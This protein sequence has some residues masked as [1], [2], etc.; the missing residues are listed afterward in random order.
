MEH[1]EKT[2]LIKIAHYYFVDGMTQ[3]EIA[4]KLHLSRQK[5]NRLIKE[6]REKGIV[7]IE[8]MTTENS[9]VEL[10]S[11]L[12]AQ[13][14]IGSGHYIVHVENESTIIQQLG[15]IGAEHFYQMC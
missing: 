11:Y 15:K 4:K 2:N 12:R 13:N 6:S 3:G 5:V 8:I 14:W 10:E 1:L 9:Y 7:K